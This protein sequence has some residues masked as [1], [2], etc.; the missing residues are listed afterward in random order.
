M[1]NVK[2][3]IWIFLIVLAANIKAHAQEVEVTNNSVFL[4]NGTGTVEML[5]QGELFYRQNST[6][7]SAF[8]ITSKVNGSNQRAFTTKN[9]NWSHVFDVF[10]NGT[11][12]ANGVALTSDETQKEQINELGTQLENIKQ[13]KPVS[14][15][16]KDKEGKG[17]KTNFGL[18][19]Q[20][21]EKVYP[22]MV[23]T[24]DQGNKAIFYTELI[25]VL[26]EAVQEQQAIIE[27]QQKQL[28][29]IEQRL[30]NLEKKSK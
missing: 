25:P 19:A 29:G 8:G 26:L 17:E 1:K 11:V 27:Q 9:Q 21:L 5:S 2:I 13:L 4:R 28:L 10:G 23:F 18:L 22:E 6:S 14:Y 3:L 7:S 12:L 30:E 24:D 16:W 15:K 20:D